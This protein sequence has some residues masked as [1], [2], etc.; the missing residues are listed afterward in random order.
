MI[1][2]AEA[3]IG[4]ELSQ[5]QPLTGEVIKQFVE[6]WERPG[7]QFLILAFNYKDPESPVLAWL[8]LPL[9]DSVIKSYMETQRAEYEA[10][11]HSLPK[12]NI[13]PAG[14]RLAREGGKLIFVF[15]TNPVDVQREQFA[16]R[17]VPALEEYAEM[18]HIEPTNIMLR[19]LTWAHHDSAE[20]ATSLADFI[21]PSEPAEAPQV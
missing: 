16:E 21:K 12:E 11:G 10:R 1:M 20:E 3:P 2:S 6:Q 4:N 15:N 17:V 8:A 7:A 19:F 13:A 18:E 14:C 9:E 5:G